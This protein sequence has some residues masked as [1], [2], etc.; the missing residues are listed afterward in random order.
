MHI[1]P[2]S[3]FIY[4]PEIDNKRIP[5]FW[6][7]KFTFYSKQNEEV[8]DKRIGLN[9]LRPLPSLVYKIVVYYERFYPPLPLQG[10]EL[11]SARLEI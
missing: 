7:F 2:Y 3:N 5:D 9:S 11:D 6:S 10:G 4:T 1:F 8:R